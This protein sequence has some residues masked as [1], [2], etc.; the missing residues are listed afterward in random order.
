MAEIQDKGGAAK[1]ELCRVLPRFIRVCTGYQQRSSQWG[2]NNFS[3]GCQA[4]FYFIFST[5]RSTQKAS[6][7]VNQNRQACF[8][9]QGIRKTFIDMMQQQ[10]AIK[11]QTERRPTAAA[12][13]LGELSAKVNTQNARIL[14]F[15]LSYKLSE[16]KPTPKW[17]DCVLVAILKENYE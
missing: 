1:Q 13:I 8:L 14:F 9:S 4:H 10:K 16:H 11:S 3:A 7:R 6:K 17:S 12:T 15:S 2:G 5:W